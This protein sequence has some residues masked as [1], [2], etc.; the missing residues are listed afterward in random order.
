MLPRYA[1]YSRSHVGQYISA[2]TY[3]VHFC[4]STP[5]AV[6][7]QQQYTSASVNRSLR[8]LYRATHFR[9][10]MAA[11]H[12]CTPPQPGGIPLHTRYTCEYV[13]QVT[14]RHPT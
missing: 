7:L 1:V 4:T 13:Y 6:R 8:L 9:A 5:F 12:F 3:A 11:V 2:T 10:P 14:M